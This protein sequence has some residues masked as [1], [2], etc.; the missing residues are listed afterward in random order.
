MKVSTLFNAFAALASLV[1]AAPAVGV[2]PDANSTRGLEP[3]PS[4]LSYEKVTPITDLEEIAAA[5][6]EIEARQG[7]Y[8]TVHIN[9]GGTSA[10]ISPV[11]R[12]SC[13][14][15]VP[16][17]KNVI[18]GDWCTR[19]WYGPIYYPGIADLTTIGWNDH[20]NS[21]ICW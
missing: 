15:L 21:F 8:V 6:R 12:G 4:P 18:S 5:K 17:W 19:D 7:V 20:I 9:W 16:A 1:V 11:N 10:Y 2:S 14:D 13:A 3:S